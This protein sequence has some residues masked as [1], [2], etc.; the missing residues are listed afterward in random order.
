MELY[1][2]Q[3]PS[4]SLSKHSRTPVTCTFN[5]LTS[6][7]SDEPLASLNVSNHSIATKGNIPAHMTVRMHSNR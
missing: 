1:L 4:N 2:A 5:T 3:N 6:L 7:L